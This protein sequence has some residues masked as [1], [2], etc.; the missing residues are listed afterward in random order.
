M[1]D[2]DNEP[3]RRDDILDRLTKQALDPLSAGEL[4]ERIAVLE[5]EIARVTAHMAAAASHKAHAE[6]FF[7]KR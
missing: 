1:I 7:K 5:G 6:S 4:D 3:R 2:D